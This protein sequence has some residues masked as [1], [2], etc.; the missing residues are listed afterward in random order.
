MNAQDRQKPIALFYSYA[1]EDERLLKSL[2]THMSA[3]RHQGVITEWHDQK[4]IAG[5]ER[6]QSI[7]EQF[8]TADIILLLISPDFLASDYCYCVEMQHALARHA[9]GEARVIPVMLRPVDWQG[10]P[11][12]RLQ[13]VP[14]GTKAIT[15][16]SDRDEALREVATAI[17]TAVTLLRASTTGSA[18]NVTHAT[19]DP[20][21]DL[22]QLQSN[23]Q[24]LYHSCVLSY[25]AEDHTFVQKLYR[26]LQSHGVS[27]WFAPEDL[28]IGSKIRPQI[29]K[30]LEEKKKVVLVLSEHAVA[31]YWV[32]SEV[33]VVFERER[34]SP[35]MLVLFPIRLD[36]A[37][38]HTHTAWA[39][40]IRRMRMIGDF[41]HWQDESAYQRALQRLL[42]DLHT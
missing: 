16:W 8:L 40:N 25:A 20:S 6:Q 38:M 18:P 23:S 27:C 1:P 5:S 39:G 7:D 22:V 42:R 17:R 41:R 14:T 19:L 9:A 30:A 11:F 33:E 2:Q 32:E 12:A 36:E 37:V 31:S 29:Y 24:A 26:D 10:T 13:Y 15:Q 3:L 4:L 34:L 21:P 28:P 35:G